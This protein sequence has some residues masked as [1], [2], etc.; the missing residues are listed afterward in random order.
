[1]EYQG[2]KGFKTK[3][4][5]VGG[6]T[7]T[8]L[9]EN[10]LKFLIEGIYENFDT[11]SLE[12]FTIEANPGTLTKSKLSLLRNLGVNRISLGLQAKQDNLLKVLGRCHTFE[13][14]RE[15]YKNA[16]KV[17]FRNISVDTIF[18]LPNQKIEDFQETLNYLL[19]IE[20]DHI[21]C[22]AL[23]IEKGTKFYTL[24]KKGKLILPSEENERIMYHFARKHLTQNGF[25]HY[26]ISNFAKQGRKSKHNMVYWNDGQ[27]L[28]LG[29]S[30]HSYIDK[31][32][33]SNTS[34]V[35]KYIENLKAGK[36]FEENRI[37]LDENEHQAEFCFMG[38]R[39]IE[40]INKNV[41]F[42]KFN[43]DIHIV[44]GDAISKLRKR[45]LLEENGRFLKLSAKGLD[46]ANE[47]FMEFLP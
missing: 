19:S 44:Y 9:N 25:E 32:R 5:Y 35:K 17:G 4:I 2:Q 33:F 1:M 45:G 11:S 36:L 14:F 18:G 46:F 20:V 37:I 30:A 38:L 43:K 16:R 26:E 40:G 42:Q 27:Y 28:G 24:Y 47:V 22:Y 21:S 23:S 34:S 10:Q 3:T 8:I 41:F 6:G 13:D 15:S 31:E 29:V 12:E 39:L 7:P